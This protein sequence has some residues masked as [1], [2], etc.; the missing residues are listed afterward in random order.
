MRTNPDHRGYAP[1]V[2]AVPS[3]RTPCRD[4]VLP[5]LKAAG[6]SD[7]QIQPEYPITNG[8][9]ISVGSKHRRAHAL[10]DDYMPE[11]QPGLPI[12]VVEAER[13]HAMPGEGM[14]QAESYARFFDV[15]FAYSTNGKG[16]VEDDR[17]SGL[18]RENL[19][20]FP[21]PAQLWVPCVVLSADAHEWAPTRGQMDLL[22]KEIPAGLYRTSQFVGD[23]H[24][25]FLGSVASATAHL[26]APL[27]RFDRA[28]GG[29]Q[30]GVREQAA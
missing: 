23:T 21:S 13:D 22:G 9:I 11:H 26:R 2:A 27:V 29:F 17:D 3:K 30:R 20:A 6:W 18:E 8:R 7:D 4:Y 19:D 14:Q 1:C 10:R 24:R 25:I 16:I 15:P 28:Y 12:A 5:R